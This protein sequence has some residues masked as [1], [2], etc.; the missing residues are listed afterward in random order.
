MFNIQKIFL[1]NL[2]ETF[3]IQVPLEQGILRFSVSLFN[4]KVTKTKTLQNQ[5]FFFYVFFSLLFI[6]TKFQIL[7]FVLLY[8]LFLISYSNIF[9]S[10]IF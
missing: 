1:F 4:S 10:L 8:L 3:F 5:Q 6:S 7:S 9:L 2:L